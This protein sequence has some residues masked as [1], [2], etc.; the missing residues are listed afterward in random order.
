[1]A[2]SIPNYYPGLA[3]AKVGKT[4][5]CTVGKEGNG[6]TY[7]GYSITDLSTNCCFEEVAH[8]L[9]Y[10]SL[11]SPKELQAY[12]TRLEGFRELPLDLQR[13]L[14]LI[15]KDAHPMDVVKT[16]AAVLGT[17][18]PEGP[19]RS[20]HDIFDTLI[21][22]FGGMLLY[23]YNFH[24]S[25][26]RINTQGVKGDSIAAGFMRMLHNNDPHPLHVETFD[27]SLILYAEHGFAASTFA[28]RVITSTRLF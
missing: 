3:G 12:K 28:C 20:A 1:M 8:L 4:A 18:A 5:I 27:K 26:T 15:P 24:K 25:G 2:A 19:S 14:E 11:P 21:S 23:W 7:R 17:M 16:G 22:S 6:L 13:A 10:G 9:I